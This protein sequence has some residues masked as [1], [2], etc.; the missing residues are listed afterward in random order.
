MTVI[1]ERGKLVVGH[2]GNGGFRSPPPAQAPDEDLLR[3]RVDKLEREVAHLHKMVE[4]L[5]ARR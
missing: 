5:L 2:V 3:R 1:I 4:K